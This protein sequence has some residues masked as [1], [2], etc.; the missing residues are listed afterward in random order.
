[1][2]SLLASFLPN[3]PISEPAP[4]TSAMEPRRNRGVGC[5]RLVRG[6][7]TFIDSN[8]SGPTL[9]KKLGDQRAGHCARNIS[10]T[11]RKARK[12]IRGPL[13]SNHKTLSGFCASVVKNNH[14]VTES[15]EKDETHP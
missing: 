6:S 7:P 9:F 11:P 14:G 5:I 3:S 8:I 15:T 12:E 1:M 2:S 13:Q 4:R 10:G